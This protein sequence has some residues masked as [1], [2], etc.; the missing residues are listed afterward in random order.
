MKILFISHPSN[1]HLNAI[2]K[3]SKSL[4]SHGNEVEICTAQIVKSEVE[5][6][7]HFL[8]IKYVDV[9]PFGSN[10]EYLAS[11]NYK[12]SYTRDF[13]LR[14]SDYFFINRSHLLTDLF[15]KCVPN[16]IFLD[17]LYASDLVIFYKLLKKDNTQV[18]FFSTKPSLDR[19]P[20]SP[21]INTVIIPQSKNQVDSL[22]RKHNRKKKWKR[23]IDSFRYF[24][25]D[26][27]S[28]LK[29]KIKLDTELA[30][31]HPLVW[32]N[33]VGIR[34][35]HIPQII[36]LPK[37]FEFQPV[38][39]LPF[40]HYVGFQFY[41]RAENAENTPNYEEVIA[42]LTRHQTL[43]KKIVYCSFGD[44]YDLYEEEVLHFLNKLLTSFRG[45]EDVFLILSLKES[46][47]K[48]L[49][50]HI[51]AN[52]GIFNFVPQLTVLSKADIFITHGGINSIKEAIHYQVPLLVYPVNPNW[53]QPGNSARVAYH[54]LGLRG[55]IKQV[56][57]RELTEKITYLLQHQAIFKENLKKMKAADEKYDESYFLATFKQLIEHK[58][59]SL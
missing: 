51:P 40:Q 20:T 19:T 41:E 47:A 13:Y 52:V 31:N 54:Q 35:E 16:I 33:V 22:W 58:K 46:V 18:I 3:I 57:G 17:I 43:G 27:L 34:F 32:K 26:D 39:P 36:L 23:L 9:M 45:L 44:V 49:K 59:D 25:H 2:A 30:M 50:I 42:L 21:P 38:E 14:T 12:N 53:D 37:A 5:K 6:T 4:V 15:N 28:I 8:S 48:N 1:S 11:K 29:D 10:F 24:L 56:T 55:D 7:L